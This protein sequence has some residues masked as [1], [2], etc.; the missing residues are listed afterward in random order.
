MM[1]MMIMMMMMMMMM[2]MTDCVVGSRCSDYLRAGRSGVPIPVGARFS[3]RVHAGPNHPAE[4]GIAG[5]FAWGKVVGAWRRVRIL[6]EPYLYLSSVI[7]WFV[8]GLQ[9]KLSFWKIDSCY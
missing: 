5:L 6:V 7:S 2:M 1:M 8:M 9:N 3:G 4:Q